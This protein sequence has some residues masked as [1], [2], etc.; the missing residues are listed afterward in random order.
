MGQ[1]AISGSG[2]FQNSPLPEIAL[3]PR[4]FSWFPIAWIM[5]S[6][7]VRAAICPCTPLGFA[8]MTTPWVLVVIGRGLSVHSHGNGADKDGG[9]VGHLRL[10]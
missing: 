6:T 3:C 2:E 5:K 7:R 4:R 9:N 8:G 10:L 1:R